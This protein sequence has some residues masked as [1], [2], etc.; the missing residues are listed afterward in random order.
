MHRLGSTFTNYVIY[1]AILKLNFNL[2]LK[3]I[4]QLN[5][6]IYNLYV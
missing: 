4:T 3:G 1:A 5:N 6:I 2:P